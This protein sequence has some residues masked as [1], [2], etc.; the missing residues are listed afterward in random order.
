M[1]LEEIGQS[2]KN[3]ISGTNIAV[4]TDKNVN[5]LYTEVV[6]KSL[7]QAGFETEVFVVE[8]GEKSKSGKVYLELLE[9]LGEVPL[10][11]TDGILALGGGVVGDLAGFAAATY[12][13]GIKVIQVPTTLLAAVDSSVGGKTGINL[14]TGKNLAGA[15]HLPAL[16]YLDVRTL[17]TL[18]RKIF[19][20]G[21]A[22]VIKYG[23]L[24]GGNLFEV[25]KD[26]GLVLEE[27][28][29]II[30]ECVAI[31]RE[32]V[33]AD[34]YDVGVRQMLN[35][36]HTFAHP[37]EKLSNY[38]VSHGEA[39]AKGMAFVADLSARQGWCSKT[40]AEDIN[41]ILLS[42]GFEL[43]IDYEMKDIY[44]I[45]KTDKKRKG[46]VIDIVI[47]EKIGKCTL[48][49]IGIEELGNIL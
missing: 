23:V 3:I 26:K 41:N 48:K 38:K 10:T 43:S 24:E 12:L 7:E 20:D 49:R 5:R 19:R 6:V 2:V 28:E 13:R 8:P 15:F 21:M 46:N 22:E 1:R 47:P 31:K 9:F 27:M 32:Y 42:Y 30:K 17:D 16:V 40:C 18:P 34:R 36:G 37:I 14:S 45:L 33:E 25:L 35:L 11:R 4:V 29:K 44:D 39:V